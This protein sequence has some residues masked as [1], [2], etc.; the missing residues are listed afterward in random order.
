MPFLYFVGI[1][2][3][4]FEFLGIGFFVKEWGIWLFLLEVIIS[5]FT[6]IL[7]L[8]NM[9]ISSDLYGLLKGKITSGSLIGGNIARFIGAIFLILPGILSDIFGIIL[10]IIAFFML[11]YGFLGKTSHFS[12][13]C[14]PKTQDDEVIDVEIIDDIKNH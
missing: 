11:R 1:L 10:E 5:G 3:L 7:I 12:Q 13:S 2:Y 14:D 8:A 4:I 6:G 9:N